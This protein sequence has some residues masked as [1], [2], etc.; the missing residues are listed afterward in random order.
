M[1]V[2]S[3]ESRPSHVPHPVHD[4]VLS[5]PLTKT[6][7]TRANPAYRTNNHRESGMYGSAIGRSM[8]YQCSVSAIRS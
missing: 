7:L 3:A 4:A 8:A 2:A 5:Y 6:D 1:G